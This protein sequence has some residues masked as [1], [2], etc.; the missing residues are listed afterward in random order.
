MESKHS[1]LVPV[2]DLFHCQDGSKVR[3]LGFIKKD[4]QDRFVIE[5]LSRTRVNLDMTA[6]IIN[7]SPALSYLVIG[8]YRQGTI[9]CQ[10]VREVKFSK[11]NLSFFLK[12]I[13]YFQNI[14]Y[15]S[16]N[17]DEKII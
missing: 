3:T 14:D 4:D 10:I 15:N 5:G 1:T 7:P 6:N 16:V 11:Y 9:F 12:N 2:E 13:P 17:I 8:D